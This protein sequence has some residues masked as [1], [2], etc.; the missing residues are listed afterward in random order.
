MVVRVRAH[1]LLVATLAVGVVVAGCGGAD[2]EAGST[3]SA[4]HTPEQTQNRTT[5]APVATPVVAARNGPIPHA[6]R[7]AESSAEDTIDL[8]LAGRRARVVAKADELRAVAN[9]AA[10]SALSKAGVSAGE[11]AEFRARAAEVARL[12][13]RADLGGVALASNRAFALMPDFFAH[14]DSP[15][16]PAVTALDHLDF[17]AKL[18]ARAG[19][20]AAI[21]PAVAQLDGTWTALRPDVVGAAGGS[22]V[23][24]RF[25]AH[26]ARMH[27]LA[28][29]GGH[30]AATEA[31]RGLDLVDEIE[32]VY[33]H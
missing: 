18:Q 10:A 8:A 6:L 28:A 19:H 21:A 7:T 29:R 11:I 23:A 20:V 5:G 12:A 13:P 17:E 14:Y 25:D 15:I 22:H 16:P 2:D 27:R 4:T 3:T 31:Q 24:A 9:G 33:E 26:V 32:A 30:A 1:A